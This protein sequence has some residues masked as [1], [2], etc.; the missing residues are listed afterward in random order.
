LGT[1]P[2]AAVQWG[3]L[4]AVAQTPNWNSCGVAAKPRAWSGLKPSWPARTTVKPQPGPG[5]PRLSLVT[6]NVM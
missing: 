5:V 6:L 2:G 3:S 1:E 4:L